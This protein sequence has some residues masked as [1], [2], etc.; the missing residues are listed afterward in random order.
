M[1]SAHVQELYQ[2]HIRHLSRADQ[3][4]LVA[5]IAQEAAAEL[6]GGQLNIMDLHGLGAELWAGLDAQKYVD[7]LRKEWGDRP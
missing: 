2:H 5:M 4:R 3:M 6:G 1:T 7:D